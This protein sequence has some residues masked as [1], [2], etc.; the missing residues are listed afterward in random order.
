MPFTPYVPLGPPSDG[1][2]S[3]KE[4]ELSWGAGLVPPGAE[5]A[6]PSMGGMYVG[7]SPSMVDP[8][9][10]GYRHTGAPVGYAGD[11][12]SG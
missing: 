1:A 4:T 8:P 10:R 2:A 5:Y 9:R 7:R 11:Q 6:P 12:I 3:T